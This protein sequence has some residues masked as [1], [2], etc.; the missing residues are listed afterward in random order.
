MVIDLVGT[1]A[2]WYQLEPVAFQKQ[3]KS[4]DCIK[5][6]N[7]EKKVLTTLMNIY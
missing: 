7:L 3:R 6:N 5:T 4:Q 2:W 1:G